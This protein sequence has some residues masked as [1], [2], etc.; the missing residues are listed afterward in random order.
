MSHGPTESRSVPAILAFNLS[1]CLGMAAS[2]ATWSM[3]P[4]SSSQSIIGVP[5]AANHPVD[6][7]KLQG[8]TSQSTARSPRGMQYSR[9]TMEALRSAPV[10]PEAASPAPGIMS[11][12]PPLITGPQPAAPALASSFQGILDTGWFPA[13]CALAVGTQR[14]IQAVNSNIRITNLTNGG[15][16]NST[17]KDLL[18]VPAG[19]IKSPGAA[20]ADEE[21]DGEEDGG[22]DEDDEVQGGTLFDPVVHYD[23]FAGRFVLVSIVTNSTNTDGWYIIAV[24]KTATPTTSPS[25]WFVYHIRN[26]LNGTT[27]TATWGDYEKLGFDNTYFYITSNQFNSS[28]AFQYAKIR[29]YTKS[30]FYNGQAVSGLEWNQV[31]NAFAVNGVYYN[32][33][34]IQPAVH[35]GAPGSGYLTSCWNG[36]GVNTINVFRITGNSLYSTAVPGWTAWSIPAGAR[37]LGSTKTLDAGDARLLSAVY[38]NNRLYTCHTVKTSFANCAAHYLGVNTTNNTRTL[39]ATMWNSAIDFYYPAVTVSSVGNVGTVVNFSS[40][41][42]DYPSIGYTQIGANGAIQSPIGV[43]KRGELSYYRVGS[44]TKN[45][46]G[47]YNGLCRD[48]VDGKRI[49]FNAMYAKS[50]VNTWGTWVGSATTST[51]L[52]IPSV[53]AAFDTTSN[54]LSING[55]D[56]GDN[57]L[58][59]RFW[60]QVLVTGVGGTLVNGRT[61]ATFTVPTTIS[62]SANMGNGNDQLTLVG[63]KLQNGNIDLGG[64]DDSSLIVSSSI[65]DLSV[66]G[67]EGTDSLSAPGSEV[68]N[69]NSVSIP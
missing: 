23:H 51:T 19:A 49:W 41:A 21:D 1:L 60:N 66:D 9:S 37:Q 65:A 13:D 63:V 62:L 34:T 25:S 47:D 52:L 50:P 58:V 10:L 69:T 16:S 40:P 45:R 39:D 44:G 68:T 4:A 6:P 46:W 29:R 33:F 55:D 17:L 22:E 56:A 26:D 18:G 53:Q 61:A 8:P 64:G 5:T 35:F 28:G 12:L 2:T 43:L 36:S 59:S 54:T 38:Q 7:S 31:K 27:D 15:A 24:S 32:A 20:A 14:V 57:V 42:S 30:Q 67:G 11:T 48:P 3:D